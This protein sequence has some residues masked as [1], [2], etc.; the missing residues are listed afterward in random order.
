MSRWLALCAVLLIAACGGE[1]SGNSGVPAEPWGSL[2]RDSANSGLSSALLEN[3]QGI[4]TLLNGD[5]GGV[6]LSTP[7][8]ASNG[9]IYLGTENGLVA[10]DN[11]GAEVW[12]FEPPIG[13][14]PSLLCGACVERELQAI[15]EE[16][17]DAREFRGRVASM[18]VRH[19][20]Y[21]AA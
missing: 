10:L 15:T 11:T 19:A 14:R 1:E 16:T 21:A 7:I 6:T 18:G 8:I 5:V 3:N 13:G 12:R 2:R 20:G 4:V 9:R 17:L